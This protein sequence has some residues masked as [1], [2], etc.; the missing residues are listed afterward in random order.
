MVSVHTILILTIAHNCLTFATPKNCFYNGGHKVE[1]CIFYNYI[2][3]VAH[4][5]YFSNSCKGYWYHGL[6]IDCRFWLQYGVYT[7][8]E[9]TTNLVKLTQYY[10]TT[11]LELCRSH[12]ESHYQL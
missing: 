7:I 10:I 12:Y 8:I 2:Q 1:K 11:Q 3:F 4:V 5:V 9:F 6:G